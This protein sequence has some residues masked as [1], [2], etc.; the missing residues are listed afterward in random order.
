M[1]R[2]LRIAD[3][4]KAIRHVFI[5]NLE[6][7][8]HIGVH[9]HEQGKPSP[10]A[11][12]SI[13]GR[14]RDRVRQAR[15]RGGLWRNSRQ[16]PRNHRSRPHQS[17]RD[18]G[19]THR[20]ACFDDVRVKTARRAGGKASRAARRGIRRRGD[21]SRCG[22]TTLAGSRRDR[23]LRYY[24]LAHDEPDTTTPP[25]K[26]LARIQAYL[27]TLPDAPGV[28]RMLDAKGDVLYVGKAKSLKKRVA[29]YAKTGG[30]TERIA[31]MIADTAEMLFVTTASRNRS[32]AARIQSH[33]AAEAALQRLV[34]AT[35]NPSRTFCC[36]RI[37]PFR[38]S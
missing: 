18:A 21:Q 20:Q 2:A 11:S 3:A 35:T 30:H 23:L 27:K 33:Q 16:D 6:V 24:I 12:M 38:R 5:R 34:S 25:L 17:R 32:A 26:G 1:Y 36:A 37:T 29:S 15:K 10:C 19:R 31:R 13:C 28:Y 9:G 22:S 8:A 4:A 7:L 14:G